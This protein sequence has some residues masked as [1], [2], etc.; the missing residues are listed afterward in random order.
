MQKYKQTECGCVGNGIKLVG[1]TNCIY[2]HV[3]IYVITLRLAIHP[4]CALSTADLH[5]QDKNEKNAAG[6]LIIHFPAH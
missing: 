1:I 6:K 5:L 2:L 4:L 3:I